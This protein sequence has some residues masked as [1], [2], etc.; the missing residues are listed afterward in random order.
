MRP[1]VV[2]NFATWHCVCSASAAT[3]IE[4]T[5]Q[6][7]PVTPL[8]PVAATFLMTKDFRSILVGSPQASQLAMQI[9]LP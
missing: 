6:Y 4:Q 3:A 1:A 5:W 2:V 7:L 8:L 9:G